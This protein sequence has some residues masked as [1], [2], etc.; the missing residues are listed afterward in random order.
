MILE[1]VQT[2]NFNY[3]AHADAVHITAAED[4]RHYYPR[5]RGRRKT[6]EDAQGDGPVPAERGSRLWHGGGGVGRQGVA[7][8]RP[9]VAHCVSPRRPLDAGPLFGTQFD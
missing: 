3:T 6:G 5:G 1:L 9:L 2:F 8:G 7:P 4:G